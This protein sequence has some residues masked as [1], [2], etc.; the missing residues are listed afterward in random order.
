MLKF[1]GAGRKAVAS[2]FRAAET[3][4]ITSD[5]ARTLPAATGSTSYYA[6]GHV[7]GA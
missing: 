7:L 2:L 5:C 3:K 1:G 6:R 4:T